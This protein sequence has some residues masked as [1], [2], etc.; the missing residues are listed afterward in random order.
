M[1]IQAVV[2]L[3]LSKGELVEGKYQKFLLNNLS[4]SRFFFHF[5]QAWRI[6]EW[7]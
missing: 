3:S 2:T 1:K 4:Y 7:H 6:I 5:I